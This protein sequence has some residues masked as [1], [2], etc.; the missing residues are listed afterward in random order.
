MATNGSVIYVNPETLHQNPAFTNVVVATSPCKT[1]YIGGQNAVDSSG[2]I[3]G[4]DAA[5]QAEQVMRNMEAALDA[6]GARR[7]HIVKWNVYLVQGVPL[8]DGFA[9]FQRFWGN[10]P[11]P[12]TISMLY[13][14]GL[15]NPAYLMEIDAIA[16][17]PL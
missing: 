5:T 1:I 3:V 7:E 15:A 13:V 10:R 17:M 11:N 9:A 14:V 16:V 12:P 4:D 2:A 8:Q 6:V